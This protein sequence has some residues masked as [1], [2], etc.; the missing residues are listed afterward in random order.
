MSILNSA[1]AAVAIVSLATAAQAAPD[2]KTER[3][4][5][6][7]CASCHG[8][9]GKGDTDQGKKLKVKDYTSAEWQASK[10]DDQLK[11][12]IADGVPDMDGFKGKLDEEQ[13]GNLVGFVRSLKK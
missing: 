3:T 11:K 12:A 2:K 9:E 10:T 8:A 4:W 6:A 1:L 7:K 13:I 5:K